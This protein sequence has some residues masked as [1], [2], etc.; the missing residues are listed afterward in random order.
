MLQVAIVAMAVSEEESCI[1]AEAPHQL[2]PLGRAPP[3]ALWQRR[4]TEHM[5]SAYC[6]EAAA[7]AAGRALFTALLFPLLA[8]YHPKGH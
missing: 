1:S 5:E 4:C 6:T 8:K 2:A 7:A 3:G